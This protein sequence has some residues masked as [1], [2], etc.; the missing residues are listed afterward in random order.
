MNTITLSA[1]PY[2][3]NPDQLM[4]KLHLNQESPY[5]DEVRR[6]AEE[7][8]AIGQPKAIYR[9]GFIEEKGHDY[10]IVDGIKLT[11]RVLCV[12]L[13]QAH[14]VFAYVATCGMELETWSTSIDDMLER[15]WADCI[16]EMAL[17]V[18]VR[19]LNEH[20]KQ[21]YR[22]G[23]TSTMNPGSLA[24]WP[25][26]EQRTLFALLGDQTEAIGVQLTPSCLMIPN[27]TVSGSWGW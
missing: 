24:D 15:Y 5:V 26:R 9:L 4:L 8:Q 18:A 21:R 3:H 6:L 16:K 23:P 14:R 25:L 12:N 17:G 2:Q 22:P 19:T 11:S 10:V 20:I 13:A 1:I 7:A 27:K